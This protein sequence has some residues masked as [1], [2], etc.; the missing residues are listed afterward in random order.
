M[1]KMKKWLFTITALLSVIAVAGALSSACSPTPP[2]VDGPEDPTGDLFDKNDAAVT[3]DSYLDVT[4]VDI[5]KDGEEY[6][7]LMKLVGDIPAKT[8][9]PDYYIEWD[10]MIDAD[11]NCGTGAT[12]S[13]VANNLGFE[14]IANNIGYEYVVS[15]ILT[16]NTYTYQIYDM[17]SYQDSEISGRVIGNVVELTVPASVIGDSEAFD[18]TAAAR[19]YPSGKGISADSTSVSDKVPNHGHFSYPVVESTSTPSIYQGTLNGTWSQSPWDLEGTGSMT[20]YSD[21]SVQGSIEGDVT[22]T[23]FGQVD[24]AG[25]IDCYFVF[26]PPRGMG[27]IPRQVHVEVQLSIS[28]D[29]MSLEWSDT[30]GGETVTFSATGSITQ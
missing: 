21:S 23:M 24:S 5:Q 3:G 2:E 9:E 29:T 8:P 11:E 17:E 22:G 1:V 12:W 26:F 14:L 4:A 6:I 28:G 30:S 25:N 7:F 20:I 15:L 16:G 27:L 13:L 10:F 18:W 19:E